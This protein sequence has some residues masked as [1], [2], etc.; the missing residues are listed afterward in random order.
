MALIL[1]IE[2]SADICSAALGREGEVMAWMAG[3]GE[4]D[5]SRVLTLLIGRLLREQ[6]VT[7]KDLDAVAVSEGPGSYTGLRIGVSTAKGMAYALGIPLVAVPTLDALARSVVDTL[8]SSM[9]E[10]LGEDGLLSPMIDA[11]RMEVYSALYDREGRRLTE[12]HPHIV[13]ERY[14]AGERA[15]H[16]V[17]FFGTGSNKCREVLNTPS[18]LFLEGVVPSADKLVPLAEERYRAG[19]F[20]DVAYFEPFYL[21]EFVATVPRDLLGR[22]DRNLQGGK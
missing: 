16:K 20:A 8:S 18:D 14:Y 10:S 15:R 6:G 13:D 22:T 9:A 11:R 1:N 17:L 4:R 3:E 12:I 19:E 5:H 21:K 2:T 7:A